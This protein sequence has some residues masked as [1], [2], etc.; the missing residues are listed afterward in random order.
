MFF[1]LT[2]K[3]LQLRDVK[4]TNHLFTVYSQNI[5]GGVG[6]GGG[7]FSAAVEENVRL[8][9]PGLRVRELLLLCE[10]RSTLDI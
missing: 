2:E 9:C 4:E 7:L 3:D 6:R 10:S 5:H 8:L 1:R